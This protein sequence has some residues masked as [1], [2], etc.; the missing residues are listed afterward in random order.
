MKSQLLLPLR[1]AVAEVVQ[2]AVVSPELEVAMIGGK[3]AIDDLRYLDLKRVQ[4][5]SP[6]DSATPGKAIKQC[7]NCPKGP[8]NSKNPLSAALPFM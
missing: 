8:I 7:L 6:G 4:E 5:K 1:E 2:I 3:P